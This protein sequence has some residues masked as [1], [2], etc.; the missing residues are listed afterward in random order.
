MGADRYVASRRMV[1]QTTKI[2][3][4]A[5]RAWGSAGCRTRRDEHPPGNQGRPC[6][7]GLTTQDGRARHHRIVRARRGM[8]PQT[9]STSSPCHPCDVEYTDVRDCSRSRT[10]RPYTFGPPQPLRTLRRSLA[11]SRH[12]TRWVQN[13]VGESHCGRT[14][15]V[16][17]LEVGFA[18]DRDGSDPDQITSLLESP[19]NRSRAG[20]WATSVR[21][22]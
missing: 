10:P 3:V 12:R 9:R 14:A 8:I 19:Q 16:P 4:G 5:S 7:D 2:G 22:R 21:I 1:E 6:T 11:S 13:R 15:S 17:A 20:R 18:C